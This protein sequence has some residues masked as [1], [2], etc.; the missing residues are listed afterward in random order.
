VD[1]TRDAQNFYAPPAMIRGG[2]VFWAL[3]S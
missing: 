3:S 2:A 1:F